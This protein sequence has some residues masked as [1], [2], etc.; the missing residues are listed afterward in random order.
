MSFP[1]SSA[2][3]FRATHG[4]ADDDPLLDRH[5]REAERI[6]ILCVTPWQRIVSLSRRKRERLGSAEQGS[7]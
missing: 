3:C 1:I 7:T 6:F 2:A 5:L 4:N